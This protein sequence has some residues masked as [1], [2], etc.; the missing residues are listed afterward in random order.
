MGTPLKVI[1]F[2]DNDWVCLFPVEL[3]PHKF[4]TTFFLFLGQEDREFGGHAISKV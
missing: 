2:L 1:D 4:M 3:A